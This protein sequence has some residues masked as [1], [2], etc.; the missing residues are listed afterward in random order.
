M[1]GKRGRWLLTFVLLGMHA[2]ISAPTA[3]QT[4]EKPAFRATTDLVSLSVTVTD[5]AGRHVADL[6]ATD[7]AVVEDSR[8]QELVFFS[9]ANTALAVSLLVDTSSSM[10]KQMLLAQEAAM[11]FVARLR[12]GDVA[13]VIDFDSR[14]EVVQPLT[15]DRAKLEA[16]IHRL[17][18]GGSTS[19]YNAVYIALRQ[20]ESARA[21]SPD[22]VRR[23]VI[24]VLSDGEDTSS[25][26]TFDQVI[27]L[28]KR[29]QT[30]IYS[31][32]LG[33]AEQGAR[34]ASRL[35]GD[36]ALKTLA[37]ETGGRLLTSK[38][39]TDLSNVYNQIADELT[40]QYVLGYLSNNVRRD[41]GWRRI[42]VRMQRPNL[43]A[44]TRPGYFA[45]R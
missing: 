45:A 43:I 37:Q 3:T 8:P 23:Q 27:D 12:P 33:S 1:P 17:V 24:I 2:A 7:F 42:A 13:E 25:L 9:R 40:S 11:E 30:V 16:A 15:S 41:G 22:Q 44:R 32:S 34:N 20:G 4:G 38:G 21:Q 29:S 18:A 28:A 10:E 36:F 6:S 31:I 14:V 35:A 5:S 39:P 26:V 19:L